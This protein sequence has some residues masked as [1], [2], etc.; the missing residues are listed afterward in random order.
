MN[1]LQVNV[2]QSRGTIDFNEEEIRQQ[3]SAFLELYKDAE[4][5]E[6][7]S[8][9]AKEELSGLRKVKEALDKRRKE[10]KA[11]CLKPYEEFEVKVKDL[12][13]LFDE[14]IQLI[15]TQVKAFEEKKRADKIAKAK[16]MY[17]LSL[18][19]EPVIFIPFEQIV[20]SAW[21]NATTSIVSIQRDID[22]IVLDIN[23]FFGTVQ[24]MNSEVGPKAIEY[25]KNT[26]DAV[27]SIK[28]ITQYE[29]QRAE[30]LRRE[31]E[32]RKAE[33]ERKKQE[34]ER[35]ER[36][37]QL[38]AE[39]EKMEIERKHQEEIERVK[40]EVSSQPA[41]ATLP[42]SVQKAV[43]L[44]NAIIDGFS[45]GLNNAQ[46]ELYGF[47]MGTAQPAYSPSSGFAQSG[48]FVD[49]G[50]AQ[51]AFKNNAPALDPLAGF[52]PMGQAGVYD[53]IVPK[54][55]LRIDLMISQHDLFELEDYF[56]K[57][58]ISYRESQF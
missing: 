17:Y 25:Y 43:D 16:E 57:R 20:N 18:G 46:P 31:E 24:M 1:D 10:V 47:D 58:N 5:T 38:A 33:E 50:T 42:Q 48:P 40:K 23:E 14:P 55:R 7:M 56:K 54:I 21:G 12:L 13:S 19:K 4:F 9:K 2:M 22:K 49:M 3:I 8:I 51:S 29:A 26:L 32:K 28:I 30:I 36:E 34:A 27:A 35:I 6:E 39:R 15:D 41:S 53:P 37:R 45:T 11:E 44:A 52:T